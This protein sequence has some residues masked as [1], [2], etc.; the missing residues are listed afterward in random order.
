MTSQQVETKISGHVI[1]ADEGLEKLICLSGLRE[2]DG[3]ENG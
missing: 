2:I 3:E 1:D